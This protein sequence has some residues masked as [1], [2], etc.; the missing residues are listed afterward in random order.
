[1]SSFIVRSHP[2][3]RAVTIVPSSFAPGYTPLHTE[4]EKQAI[5]AQRKVIE[6]KRRELDKMSE[7]L[8][9]L[10]RELDE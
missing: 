3:G 4:T 2:T 8:D 9:Q 5:E 6:R 10:E 7:G 1:M